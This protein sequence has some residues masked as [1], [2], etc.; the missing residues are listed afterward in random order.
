MKGS[1]KGSDTAATKAMKGSGRGGDTAVTRAM[2]RHRV[3]RCRYHELDIAVLLNAA[4]EEM[5]TLLSPLRFHCLHCPQRQLKSLLCGPPQAADFADVAAAQVTQLHWLTVAYQLA[6]M[7]YFELSRPFTDLALPFH[8]PLHSKIDTIG[9]L[10]DS[11][12]GEL[13]TFLLSRQLV[14]LFPIPF[15]HFAPILLPFSLIFSHFDSKQWLTAA[16]HA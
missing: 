10:R 8:G 16:V 6:A 3:V 13:S 15:S 7:T 11:H 14:L 9:F 5:V 12:R 1:D 4:E 2:T